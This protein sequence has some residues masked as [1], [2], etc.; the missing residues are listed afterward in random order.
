MDAFLKII[1]TLG[2]PTIIAAFIYIGRKLQILEDLNT[3][4]N[5]IKT[6][7]KVVGGLSHQKCEQL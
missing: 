3:T 6:N 2:V 5:K 7:V 1:V 4:V